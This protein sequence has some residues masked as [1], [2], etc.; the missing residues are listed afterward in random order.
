MQDQNYGG[1]VMNAEQTVVFLGALT[2]FLLRLL[3]EEE[4]AQRARESAARNEA[5]P[6]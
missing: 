6:S 4:S 3:D 2:Y 5:V 1:I